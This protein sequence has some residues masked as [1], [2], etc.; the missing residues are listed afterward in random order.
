MTYREVYK[1]VKRA[2]GY[3][4]PNT[5]ELSRSLV[6]GGVL[7]NVVPSYGQA[8]G[9]Y[10]PKQGRVTGGTGG[11]SFPKLRGKRSE[12]TEESIKGSELIKSSINNYNKARL[13][14]NNYNEPQ[15]VGGR[16]VGYPQRE[17]SGLKPQH[18]RALTAPLLQLGIPLPT[19]SQYMLQRWKQQQRQRSR[20]GGWRGLNSIPSGKKA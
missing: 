4:I 8:T 16:W 1:I 11:M 5:A 18:V 17:P 13:Q 3:N 15:R 20:N 6:H 9:L 2:A 7:G 14:Q 10:S 12:P 19:P